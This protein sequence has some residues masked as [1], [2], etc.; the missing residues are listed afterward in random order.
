MAQVND[1]EMYSLHNEEKCVA[2]ERFIGTLTKKIQIYNLNVKKCVC[3]IISYYSYEY[4]NIYQSKTKIKLVEVMSSRYIDYS[5]ENNAK[6]LKFK[7]GDYV[8]ISKYKSIFAKGDA[9]I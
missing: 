6:D 4:N 5:L 3:Q 1:T 9:P 8:R 7:V 2:V